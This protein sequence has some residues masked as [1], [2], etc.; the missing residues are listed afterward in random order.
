M[1]KRCFVQLTWIDSENTTF[2]ERGGGGGRPRQKLR[3]KNPTRVKT[4]KG[5]LGK[6]KG[7]DRGHGKN[8]QRDIMRKNYMAKENKK[9]KPKT[10]PKKKKT[11]KKKKQRNEMTISKDNKNK[12]KNLEVII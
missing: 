6:F 7:K 9:T 4:Q 5:S 10:K 8:S 1:G 3:Q 12:N 11:K 2:K